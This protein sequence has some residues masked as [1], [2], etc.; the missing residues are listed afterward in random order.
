[1]GGRGPYGYVQ[2]HYWGNGFLRYYQVKQFPNFLLAAP[3]L[4][5]SAF[6]AYTF[7]RE[8]ITSDKFTYN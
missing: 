2:Q 7:A 8:I 1:V 6:S 3:M 4:M 5:L